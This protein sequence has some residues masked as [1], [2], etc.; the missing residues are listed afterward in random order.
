MAQNNVVSILMG[1]CFTYSV[2]EV[3]L[4]ESDDCMSSMQNWLVVSY[5]SVVLFWVV[6]KI[7]RSYSHCG[8]NFMFSFRQKSSVSLLAVCF[9]WGLLVP[10]FAV[11]TVLGSLWFR[12]AMVQNPTCFSSGTYPWLIMFWQVI[13]YIW[14]S[15][16]VVYSGIATTIECRLRKAEKNM[17]LIESDESVSRWGRIAV[18]PGTF[19]STVAMKQNTGLDPSTILALRSEVH[20]ADAGMGHDL[21][22]SICLMDFDEGDKIRPLPVCGH[23][24]HQSCIDLW[25]PRRADCPL[26]KTA[27]N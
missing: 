9:Q 25:L 15:I 26:C 22:C 17:R 6:Q 10:F 23:Y 16:Y 19:D 27:V 24:F 20:H 8:E 11:W 12:D 2:G 7:G 21:Q 18:S 4:M 13:S 1:V 5:M 3:F 14:L